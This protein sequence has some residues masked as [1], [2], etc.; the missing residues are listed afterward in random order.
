MIARESDP[1][2]AFNRPLHILHVENDPNDVFFTRVA[3]QKAVP[4]VA[5]IAVTDRRRARGPFAVSGTYVDRTQ[6]GVSN[7]TCCEVRAELL[8]VGPPSPGHSP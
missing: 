4:D 8:L 1:K 7:S 3:F 5:L 6:S 2:L